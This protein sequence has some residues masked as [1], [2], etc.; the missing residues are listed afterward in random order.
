MDIFWLAGYVPFFYFLTGILKNFVGLSTSMI[1]PVLFASTLGF[2]FLGNIS[3]ELYK[4]A[5]LSNQEG[6]VS[7]ITSSAYPMADMLLPI[8]AAAAFIQLR[9]GWL[10]FTPWAFIVIAII[11][12]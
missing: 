12:F 5:D 4:T 3:L 7:Y 11:V 1:P 6:I 2:V 9:K 8:P 10:T